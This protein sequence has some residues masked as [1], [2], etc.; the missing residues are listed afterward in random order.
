MIARLVLA[1]EQRDLGALAGELGGDGGTGDAGADDD[2]VVFQFSH[3]SSKIFRGVLW[4]FSTLP[5]GP[6]STATLPI[7]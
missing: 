1:L 4:R 6:I 2:D 7:L 3:H 5:S